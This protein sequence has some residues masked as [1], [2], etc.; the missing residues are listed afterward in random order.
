MVKEYELR[1]EIISFVMSL[2][3]NVNDVVKVR[4]FREVEYN[5]YNYTVYFSDIFFDTLFP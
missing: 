2:R 5:I 1:E 3:L 4:V